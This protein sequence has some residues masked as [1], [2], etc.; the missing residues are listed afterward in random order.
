MKMNEDQRVLGVLGVTVRYKEYVLE[1][2]MSTAPNALQTL[3][4]IHTA[5]VVTTTVRDERTKEDWGMQAANS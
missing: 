4:C 1:G 3:T 2:P 5:Q